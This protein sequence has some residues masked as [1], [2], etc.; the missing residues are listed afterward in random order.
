MPSMVTNGE[1]F[2]IGL[3]PYLNVLP[4]VT[5]S[6]FLLQQILFMPE[7]TNE[8]AVMQQKLMKYMMVFMGFMFF[9]V[10]AG[11]CLYFIVSSG[12]GIAERKLIPA[13]SPTSTK[14][15]G[16]PDRRPKPSSNRKN[17]NTASSKNGRALGKRR[18][19]KKR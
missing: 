6:L 12:W 3:G 16:P 5:M 13:A 8:Q 18:P 2:L 19:K 14:P 7:A 1:T 17:A 10:A 15:E 9:K 4:L 11:L